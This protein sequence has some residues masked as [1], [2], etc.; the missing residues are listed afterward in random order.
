MASCQ[1]QTVYLEGHGL[2]FIFLK[3]QKAAFTVSLKNMVKHYQSTSI[4]CSLALYLGITRYF[5]LTI[6]T[7]E[8]CTIN[9]VLYY[10]HSNY[11]SHYWNILD[12]WPFS[13]INCPVCRVSN[14]KDQPYMTTD[15]NDVSADTEFG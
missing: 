14:D 13:H 4:S 5:K 9:L 10:Q 1:V 12:P 3:L 7:W 2:R 6:T 11:F 15:D 8:L